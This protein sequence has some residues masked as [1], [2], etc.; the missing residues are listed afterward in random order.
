MKLLFVYLLLCSALSFSVMANLGLIHD[1]KL[2]EKGVHHKPI[3]F[4][5]LDQNHHI[6]L[7]RTVADSHYFIWLVDQ[8]GQIIKKVDLSIKL[9][10][11]SKELTS[12]H[13]FDMKVFKSE[14]YLL[15]KK[16]S[17]YRVLKFASD[18]NTLSQINFSAVF[19]DVPVE[20]SSF[21]YV[22]KDGLYVG[23]SEG[24]SSVVY[25]IDDKG[26]TSKFYFKEN[27]EKLTCTSYVVDG[28]YLSAHDQ[29]YF[30]S[31]CV[32]YNAAVSEFYPSYSKILL[33]KVANNGKLL[34][35]KSIS[36]RY[37][38][39]TKTQSDIFVLYDASQNF[40]QQIFVESLLT[41]KIAVVHQADNA[42]L[43]KFFMVGTKNT[44]GVI[45]SSGREVL[46]YRYDEKLTPIQL[47]KGQGSFGARRVVALNYDD[48]RVFL[49]TKIPGENKKMQPA[50]SV[51]FMSFSL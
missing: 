31:E 16:D 32:A 41:G 45:G 27:N 25:S 35:E 30:V 20:L 4:D 46:L 51:G 3:A 44:L 7:V 23:G 10:S 34:N 8:D 19:G 28:E 13:I 42:A 14:I 38:A 49:L 1:V 24:M 17:N 33:N 36:G 37:P 39:L 40:N 21:L 12:A 43:N 47:D 6:F 48:E 18:F 26:K 50:F 11:M 5:K 22:A 15:L 9:K 2:G 29:H